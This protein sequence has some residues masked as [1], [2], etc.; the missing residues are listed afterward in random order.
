MKYQ[1]LLV[2][3]ITR[4]CNLAGE[5]AGRCPISD[6]ARWKN[7]DTSRPMTDD[8]ICQCARIA[9]QELGFCGCV[10]WHYYNEPTL[11]L[12]RLTRLQE[13]IRGESPQAKFYLFTNGVG[14]PTDLAELRKTDYIWITNYFH[15]DWYWLTN[16]H[17]G[18]RVQ[19]YTGLDNRLRM[20]SSEQQAMLA[21]VHGTGSGLFR[22]RPPVL[23]G[24]AQRR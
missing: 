10:A 5:H 19:P 21:A 22:Q 12:P 24:L 9:Y 1:Q 23:H 20:P 4:G 16:E 14:L 6:P 17:P 11:D 18:A 8:L 15:R 3:E 7:L 2:F 13:R